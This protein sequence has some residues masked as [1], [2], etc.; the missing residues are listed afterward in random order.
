MLAELLQVPRYAS[1]LDTQ[2][3]VK[4]SRS[5]A[6]AIRVAPAAGAE[7]DSIPL[8]LPELF[9]PFRT[10]RISPTDVALGEVIAALLQVRLKFLHRSPGTSCRQAT[11]CAP[12]TYP[13]SAG[14][15]RIAPSSLPC[16]HFNFRPTFIEVSAQSGFIACFGSPWSRSDRYNYKS[17]RV[18]LNLPVMAAVTV[19]LR[20]PSHHLGQPIPA[21]SDATL[22]LSVVN[23][24]FWTAC[25]SR[26]TMPGQ[27]E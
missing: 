16:N 13:H 25:L 7:R 12:A 22:R 2:A 11:R 15:I 3:A 20:V 9:D 10:I 19:S 18:R 27:T 6:L 17:H 5:R 4:R 24:S 14:I 26:S 1:P 23:T 21:M 8:D